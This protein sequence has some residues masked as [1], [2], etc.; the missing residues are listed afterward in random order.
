MAI[1]V[2][3]KNEPKDRK[4]HNMRF[5][6]VLLPGIRLNADGSVPEEMSL[7]VW[8]AY[9]VWSEHECPPIVACGADAAGVGMSEAAMMKEMLMDLGVPEGAILVEDDS[10][11]TAENFRNAA[12][13]IG[14]NACCA[15][16]TSDYHLRR[17]KLLARRVGFKVAGFKA[18]TPG[19]RQKR[20]KYI[21]EFLGI[22]DALC[23]WQD[24]NHPR[25]GT[26]ERFKRF[27]GKHLLGN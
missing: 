2:K 3:K 10:F 24:E 26:V 18:K 14:E 23:G 9:E 20:N 12:L 5:D 8:R 7:R 25:P 16:V 19:G 1:P 21:M 4:K 27:L 17:A 15:L 13:L 11:I 22:L 6:A